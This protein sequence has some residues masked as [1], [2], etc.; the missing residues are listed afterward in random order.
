MVTA[1]NDSALWNA[2]ANISQLSSISTIF[3]FCK[4]NI[5]GIKTGTQIETIV[6]NE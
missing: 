4:P 5:K 2:V 1:K 3:R 6:E